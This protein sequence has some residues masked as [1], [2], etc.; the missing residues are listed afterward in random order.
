MDQKQS[1]T[2]IAFSTVSIHI[3]S[4]EHHVRGE[5]NP[6]TK[7]NPMVPFIAPLPLLQETNGPWHNPLPY[8]EDPWSPV[9]PSL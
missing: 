9:Q 4:P 8:L 3:F 6:N 7:P 5:P 1:I 2:L